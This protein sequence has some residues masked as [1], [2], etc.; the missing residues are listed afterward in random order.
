MPLISNEQIAARVH[1]KGQCPEIVVA[2]GPCRSGTTVFLR[3]FGQSGIQSWYQPLKSI[4]RGYLHHNDIHF[5]IPETKRLFIKE[6]LGAYI[7]NEVL[8]DPIEVLLLAG[9]PKEKIHLLSVI[10]EPYATISSWIEHFSPF[11]EREDL[12]EIG[13]LSYDSI[14]HIKRNAESLGI[15]S[16]TF[17]YESWRD[18]APLLVTHKLFDK[19]NMPFSSAALSNW[20]ALNSLTSRESNIFMLYEPP[21]YHYKDFFVEVKRSTG[22]AYYPKPLDVITRYLSPE[23]IAQIEQ[24]HALKIYEE[25]INVSERDLN[26]NISRQSIPSAANIRRA[27]HETSH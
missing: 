19:L 5:T 6:T 11:S 20:K 12:V 26:L 24:S 15:H 13:L 7:K 8:Y 10:R 22:L 2:V 25:L 3:M 18:H 16:T 27:Y 23:R 9:V 17:V 1:L 4:L 14:C 21:F